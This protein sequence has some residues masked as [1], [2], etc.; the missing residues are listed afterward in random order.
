MGYEK[1]YLLTTKQHYAFLYLDK[2]SLRIITRGLWRNR[3]IMFFVLKIVYLITLKTWLSNLFFGDILVQTITNV[4][5]E[6]RSFPK[7]VNARG[8]KISKL[9]SYFGPT[10][11][12]FGFLCRPF[13]LSFIFVENRV[14]TRCKKFLIS[15]LPKVKNKLCSIHV[16]VACLGVDW[17]ARKILFTR[18]MGNYGLSEA[19]VWKPLNRP[20]NFA[21]NSSLS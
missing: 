6:P 15:F 7:L 18:V 10:A 8:V 19:C 3:Q 12:N 21:S 16:V 11:C 5:G 20:F 14:S 17:Q 2:T 13:A 1:S 4:L 9:P